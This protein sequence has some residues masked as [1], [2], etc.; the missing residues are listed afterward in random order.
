MF[1]QIIYLVSLL[2][3]EALTGSCKENKVK[4]P[5]W[6]SK[7]TD[8]DYQYGYPEDK[9]EINLKKQKEDEETAWLKKYRED[10][11]DRED[12]KL[13]KIMKEIDSDFKILD[14]RCGK[15]KDDEISY[16]DDGSS[17]DFVLESTKLPKYKAPT[18]RKGEYSRPPKKYVS[19]VVKNMR[20]IRKKTLGNVECARNVA[21]MKGKI[22]RGM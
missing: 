12:A 22:M 14:K 1:G 18:Y 21:A 9:E 11:E 8:P 2:F 17:D 5:K 7:F 13:K 20:A 10:E 15:E 4:N 16:L 3:I 6:L 19:D